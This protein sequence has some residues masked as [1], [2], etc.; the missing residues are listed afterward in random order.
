MIPSGS[1]S[2]INFTQPFPLFSTVNL[3]GTRAFTRIYLTASQPYTLNGGTLSLRNPGLFVGGGVNHTIN[4]TIGHHFGFNMYIDVEHNSQLTV[5]GRLEGDSHGDLQGLI[6]TGAGVLR[7]NS[8]NNILD[9]VYLGNGQV[10]IAD[11]RSFGGGRVQF[12]GGALTITGTTLQRGSEFT[13]GF[14]Y[15][16]EGGQIRI[17][18]SSHTFDMD[19][20]ISDAFGADTF[21]LLKTGPGTLK[22]SANNTHQGGTRVFDGRI[23]LSANNQLGS[24]QLQMDGGGLRFDAPFTLTTPIELTNRNGGFVT[25]GFDVTID[26][27]VTGTGR[28]IKRDPGT[29]TL[30]GPDANAVSAEVTA[31]TLELAKTNAN[32]VETSLFI[33]KDAVARLAANNQ[34]AET[35]LVTVEPNARFDLDTFSDTI[36]KIDISH[37]TLALTLGPE[38][39]NAPR[40]SVDGFSY[41]GGDTEL[42]LAVAPGYTPQPLESFTLIDN[43]ADDHT[44]NFADITGNQLPNGMVLALFTDQT[45]IRG[46]AT[47]P[48]DANLDASVDLLD[49]SILASNF[50]QNADWSTADFNGD[51]RADLLDLSILASNFGTS[52]NAIPEP[53]LI[54]LLL[55]LPAL[56]RRR[57]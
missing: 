48:G 23:A 50:N 5:N 35:T 22:L 40:L 47:L 6:K 13:G 21:H 3:N 16:D 36:G 9:R 55:L 53:A 54:T 51:E 52:L 25:Q 43:R 57:S 45:G 24:G 33:H 42:A 20:P 49:L 41:L 30:A 39:P 44:G 14:G 37:G 4:S 56:R 11:A 34:I 26:A 46:I 15:S 18:E 38:S 27:P 19:V 28:L 29:L 31:G 32:A 17:A 10:S 7:I 12:D 1:N 2:Y 8:T